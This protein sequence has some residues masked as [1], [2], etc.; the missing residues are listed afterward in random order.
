[1]LN[2]DRAWIVIE[3][4]SIGDPFNGPLRL[5]FSPKK[6]FSTKNQL[7]TKMN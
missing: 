2:I 4:E 7:S 3:L 5:L 6:G 1:M